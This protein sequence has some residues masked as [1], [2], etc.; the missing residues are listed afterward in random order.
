MGDPQK[1]L[2]D[3]SDEFQKIQGGALYFSYYITHVIILTIISRTPIR[4]RRAP[5]ARI[6][7]AREYKCSEGQTLS[8][9]PEDLEPYGQM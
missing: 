5:E 7:A 2:Q 3:L 8:S 9:Q 4:R 6:P 1:K